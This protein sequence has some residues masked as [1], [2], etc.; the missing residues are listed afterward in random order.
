MNDKLKK[1]YLDVQEKESILFHDLMDLDN[2]MNDC[3]CDGESGIFDFCNTQSQNE[4]TEFC[5]DCGGMCNTS[6]KF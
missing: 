1:A 2:H 3:D 5:L 4:V 6:D